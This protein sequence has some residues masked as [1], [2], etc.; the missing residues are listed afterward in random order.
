M[1]NDTLDSDIWYQIMILWY[2][3]TTLNYM[4]RNKEVL[5]Y[6]DSIDA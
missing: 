3:H 6:A 4:F 1:V 5:L 2:C